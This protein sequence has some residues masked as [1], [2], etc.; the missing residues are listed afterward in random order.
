MLRSWA[1]L[2]LLFAS[3]LLGGGCAQSSRMVCQGDSDVSTCGAGASCVWMHV[4]NESGYFCAIDCT[5]GGACP[6][7]QACVTEAASSCQ[8][9]DDLLDVCE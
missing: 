6:S 7:G 4:G 1:G 9:C 5:G 2:S 3:L 8:T